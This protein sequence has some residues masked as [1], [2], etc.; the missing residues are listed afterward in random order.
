M[1]SFIFNFIV[2]ITLYCCNAPAPYST[3]L[4]SAIVYQRLIL[5]QPAITVA[6]NNGVSIRTVQRY[7]DRYRRYQTV[8]PDRYVFGETRGRIATF[9]RYDVS[10]LAHILVDDCTLYLDELQRE[11]VARGGSNVS[12]STINRWLSIMG[13]SRQRIFQVMSHKIVTLKC[14]LELSP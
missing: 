7:V 14:L 11:L 3:D 6:N 9:T 13:Y 10:I 2:C 5:Q 4:R 8:L 1:L 12:V